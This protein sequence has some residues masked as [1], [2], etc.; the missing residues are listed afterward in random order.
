MS[1]D[2]E[3]TLSTYYGSCNNYTP[4]KG[5]P[6]G[7]LIDQK[8]GQVYEC[9]KFEYDRT[10]S[11]SSEW[12]RERYENGEKHSYVCKHYTGRNAPELDWEQSTFVKDCPIYTV[13]IDKA[14]MLRIEYVFAQASNSDNYWL[15][16]VLGGIKVETLTGL[17]ISD[18]EKVKGIA[19]KL[20]RDVVEN[21]KQKISKK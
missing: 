10:I 19:E 9:S 4:I 21:L 20:L 14:V 6:I 2:S 5:H 12:A 15:I 8:L 11:V 3:G 7:G 17:K 16:N 1:M 18:A 13:T